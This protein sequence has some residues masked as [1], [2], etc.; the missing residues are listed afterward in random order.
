MHPPTLLI[1]VLMGLSLAGM[2]MVREPAAAPAPPPTAGAEPP[3]AAAR[4]P[5]V[6]EKYRARMPQAVEVARL[7]GLDVIDAEENAIGRVRD[8]VRMDDGGL[9]IVFDYLSFFGYGGRLV[10]LPI[11]AVAVVGQRLAVME[12]PIGVIA[13]TKTW[14]GVGGASLGPGEKVAVALTK[15]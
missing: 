4:E 3:P 15:F 12:M 13:K 11:E 10:P 2:A 8:V 6:A 7:I 9:H 14:Y 5:T 1:H